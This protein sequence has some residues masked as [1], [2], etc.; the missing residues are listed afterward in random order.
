[1]NRRSTS[2]S[3]AIAAASSIVAV[4]CAFG[5]ERTPFDSED[6]SVPE[7]SVDA[8]VAPKCVNLQCN[9][10]S[11]GDGQHTTISGTVYDP[12]GASPLYNAIVYVPNAPLSPFSPGVSCD[13]CGSL[14]SGEPITVTL[15]DERGGFVLEDVPVVDDLPVVIQM[16]R[17]RRQIRIE[18]VVACADNPVPATLTHLPRNRHEGDIPLY[19]LVT[20]GFDPL[21]CLMRKIGIDDEEFTGS[22]GEGRVH[23]YT[24]WGGGRVPGSRPSEALYPDLKRYDAVVLSC[25]GDTHPENKPIDATYDMLRYLDQGGR[26]YA[27]HFQYYWFAPFPDGAGLDPLPSVA[28]WDQRAGM[29]DTI[30]GVVDVNFPKG[31]AYYDWLTY[32]GAIGQ[33]GLLTVLEARR[34]IDYSV[35]PISQSWVHTD[36]HLG[37]PAAVQLLTFNTPIHA[38]PAAQCGRVVFSDMHVASEDTTGQTFPNGCV[39]KGLSAQE[40][41]LEF[42]IFDLSSCIQQDSVPPIPPSVPLK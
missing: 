42:M 34:D 33:D 37:D 7:L 19:A 6:A 21:E 30:E 17:W 14:A 25:E 20:G 4:A 35:H 11:C 38:D 1:L 12:A 3:W 36:I 2:L 13:H 27:S 9:R 8:G 26:V 5:P 18:H 22:T 23:L 15:T 41:A 16:G 31:K 10:T 32:A 28:V 24:G 40:K 29:N 39:S